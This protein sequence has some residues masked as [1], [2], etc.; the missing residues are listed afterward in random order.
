MVHVS[1]VEEFRA[2]DRVLLLR[3]RCVVERK[4]PGAN[5]VDIAAWHRSVR[6]DSA[7]RNET[8]AAVDLRPHAGQIEA[9]ADDLRVFEFVN[10]RRTGLL[11]RSR[12]RA[13]SGEAARVA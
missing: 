7:V 10:F 13:E 6:S 11:V 4:R 2:V 3:S 12:E 5:V 8:E 1:H 9:A